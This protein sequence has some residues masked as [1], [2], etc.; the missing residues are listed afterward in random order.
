MCVCVWGPWLTRKRTRPAHIHT[1]RRR[2]RNI[3]LFFISSFF[4][5]TLWLFDYDFLLALFF[6][7]FFGYKL[8]HV[9]RLLRWLNNWSRRQQNQLDMYHLIRKR[10]A[11]H[12]TQTTKTSFCSLLF[13]GEKRKHKLSPAEL[14]QWTRSCGAPPPPN[15]TDFFF[16]RKKQ[17]P[18]FFWFGKKEKQN[19]F[20]S[21]VQLWMNFNWAAYDIYLMTS[22]F[23]REEKTINDVRRHID[24]SI[25]KL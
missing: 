17:R 12:Q 20:W 19:F 18:I 15:Q 7:F 14:W 9:P 5:W 24:D 3:S 21:K 4:A 22:L 1:I 10:R 25:E 6:F 16:L 13:S 11:R 23:P 2:I 8:V